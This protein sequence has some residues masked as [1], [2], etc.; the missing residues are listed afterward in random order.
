MIKT[1]RGFM[2]R[3]LHYIKKHR[4]NIDVH[5][6]ILHHVEGIDLSPSNIELSGMEVIKNHM[7]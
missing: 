2:M 5:E 1:G 3:A 4:K 7:G 6:T